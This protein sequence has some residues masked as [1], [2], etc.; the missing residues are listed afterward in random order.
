MWRKGW[1]SNPRGSVNP[2]A[3]FKTA[4]LNR[5]A[6]LPNQCCRACSDNPV[7]NALATRAPVR[8]NRPS[9]GRATRRDYEITTR[10]GSS[11]ERGRANGGQM[12]MRA[13]AAGSAA[14]VQQLNASERAR[15]ASAISGGCYASSCGSWSSSAG[16][17]TRLGASPMALRDAIIATYM[18]IHI[19]LPPSSTTPRSRP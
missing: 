12:E 15:G 17:G 9:G 7:A 1:D 5:S 4:A 10:C 16:T 19:A 13:A 11:R 14:S 8:P 6:T 18:T 2:L 3:V